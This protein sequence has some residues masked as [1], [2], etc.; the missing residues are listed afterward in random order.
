MF[1]LIDNY[2]MKEGEMYFIKRD[3][4]IL[5]EMIFVKYHTF[6]NLTVTFATFTYPYMFVYSNLCLFTISVYRYVSEEEYF[7]KVKEKYDA[8]CLDI[9]LKRVVN[10]TFK[11]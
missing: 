5:G 10:E 2:D 11:W 3:A 6:D 1:E 7:A 4:S 8:K 9:V